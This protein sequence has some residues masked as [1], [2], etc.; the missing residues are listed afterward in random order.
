[1]TLNLR[2]RPSTV[3]QDC[4]SWGQW[5]LATDHDFILSNNLVFVNT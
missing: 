2:K 4:K 1:M 5:V 3:G